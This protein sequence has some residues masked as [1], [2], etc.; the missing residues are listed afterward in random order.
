MLDRIAIWNMNKIVVAISM[1]IWVADVSLLTYGEYFLR[2]TK[3]SLIIL[4]MSQ[5]SYG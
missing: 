4:V 1:A 5:V 2:I 3:L